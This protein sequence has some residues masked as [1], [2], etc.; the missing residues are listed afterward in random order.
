MLE[1]LFLVWFCKKLASIARDKNRSGGWGALGAIFWVGGEVSGFVVG[2]S[3]HADGGAAYGFALVGAV[4]GA[5]IAFMIVKSL[6]E[7]PQDG[8]FPNARVV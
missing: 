5:L 7:L 6:P 3:G 4:I 1:I 8:D 2:T